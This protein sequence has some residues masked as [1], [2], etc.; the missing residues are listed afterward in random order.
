[1]SVLGLLEVAM[2]R[3]YALL[4]GAFVQEKTLALV[5][6]VRY[7]CQWLREAFIPNAY[8]QRVLGVTE[9]STYLHISNETHRAGGP[10]LN[11]KFVCFVCTFTHFLDG[12]FIFSAPMF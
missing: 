10:S 11:L 1:M 6:G 3:A 5:H 7:T 4:Q 2:Q 12:N 8:D 9:V